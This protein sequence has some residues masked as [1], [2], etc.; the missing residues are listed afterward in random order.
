MRA[1]PR[2]SHY[3]DGRFVDGAVPSSTA[4]ILLTGR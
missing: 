1:Q 4:S 2:G 3:V